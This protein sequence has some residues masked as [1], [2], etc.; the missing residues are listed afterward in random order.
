M[1]GVLD[2]GGEGELMRNV[3]QEQSIVKTTTNVNAIHERVINER[4]S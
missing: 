3:V 2:H 1:S 4:F